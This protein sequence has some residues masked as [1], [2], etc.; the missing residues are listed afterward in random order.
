MEEVKN[1]IVQLDPKVINDINKKLKDKYGI[2]PTNT[3]NFRLVWSDDQYE[4]RYMYYSPEGFELIHP[5]IRLVPKY[6]PYIKERYLLERLIPIAPNPE[7]IVDIGYECCWVFQD[8]YQNYLPPAWA[9]CIFI[10]D[11]M[12]AAINS[13]GMYKKYN[14]PNKDPEHKRAEIDAMIE[15]LFGNETPVGDALTHGYGVSFAG[16]DGRS[17]AAD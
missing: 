5:E 12:F 6:R 8:R 14:D 9:P 1:R 4:K 15:Q 2:G 16:L 3:P 17:N 10:I 13:A 11:S 7:L